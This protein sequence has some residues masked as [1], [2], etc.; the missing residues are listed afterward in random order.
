MLFCSWLPLSPGFWRQPHFCT[1][2]IL[3]SFPLLASV[4]A[5]FHPTVLPTPF[6]LR[7]SNVSEQSKCL[8]PFCP[9]H[10]PGA[11]GWISPVPVLPLCLALQTSWTRERAGLFHSTPQKNISHG[12]FPGIPVLAPRC[13]D[14]SCLFADP[15]T[16]W[17]VSWYFSSTI[18]IAFF[19]CT[20]SSDISKSG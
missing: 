19:P 20:L 15:Q 10:L 5:E 9:C 7:H 16:V 18:V 11:R 6:V 12:E 1:V 3:E 14:M 17:A 4:E 8:F 13:T 2:K